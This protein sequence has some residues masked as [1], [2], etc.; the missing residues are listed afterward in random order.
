MVDMPNTTGGLARKV[1]M[2]VVFGHTE[3]TAAATDLL[4]S[5]KATVTID[6]MAGKEVR[7]DAFRSVK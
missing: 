7:D 6:F 4:S 2:E 5:S 1:K 3:I